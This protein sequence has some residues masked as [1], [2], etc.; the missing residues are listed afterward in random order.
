MPAVGLIYWGILTERVAAKSSF[1][2][3]FFHRI[4]HFY[5]EEKIWDL[6]ASFYATFYMKPGC[7]VCSRTTFGASLSKIKTFRKPIYIVNTACKSCLL[8]WGS[9]GM[10]VGYRTEDGDLGNLPGPPH[11]HKHTQYSPCTH[12]RHPPHPGR[13]PTS[14]PPPTGGSKGI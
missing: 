7:H 3:F 14:W 8:C 13:A 2:F 1:F 6:T 11:T 4:I 9:A 5:C 10:V 12:W